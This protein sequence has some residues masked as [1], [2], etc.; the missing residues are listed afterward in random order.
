MSSM[1][2]NLSLAVVLAP[3]PAD[4]KI[5][6]PSGPPPQIVLAVLKDGK[7]EVT[8]PAMVMVPVTREE[9]RTRVVNVDGKQVPVQEKVAVTSYQSR[10]VTTTLDR[11]RAFDRSGKEVD[12]K[13]LA[14][15]L[16]K[17]AV[18]LLSSDGKPVDPFYMRT[19]KEGT[20]TLVAAVGAKPA[21]LPP[22]DRPPPPPRDTPKP[23]E[24]KPLDR[25]PR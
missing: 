24:P 7:C 17:P 5:N 10:H 11:P 6:L 9:V 12:A 21:A 3:A 4:E 20:L 23:V 22:V 19:I 2:L 25:L 18:V 15:L 13:R 1:L 8:Y 14:E 16:K